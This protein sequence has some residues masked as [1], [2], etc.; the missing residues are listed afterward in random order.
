M[1]DALSNW[2]NIVTLIYLTPPPTFYVE[3]REHEKSR[4]DPY[5]NCEFNEGIYNFQ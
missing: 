5:P 2:Q 4:S 1:C 3:G